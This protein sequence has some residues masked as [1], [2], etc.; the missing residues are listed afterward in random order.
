M[1]KQGS[2]Q[3]NVS[4]LPQNMTTEVNN[5]EPNPPVHLQ[6]V[7]HNCF[8]RVIL[9]NKKILCLSFSLLFVY[10]YNVCLGVCISLCVYRDNMGTPSVFVCHSHF[11]WERELHVSLKLT[12]ILVG[13]TGQEAP[14]CSLFLPPSAG[15]IGSRSNALCKCWRSE[16]RSP[17]ALL[18][19]E[20]SPQSPVPS[21]Q[22]PV[23][24]PKAQVPYMFIYI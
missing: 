12:N 11:S 5:L 22:S 3:A 4:S 13:L 19:N 15:V 17:Q 20:P 9:K 16:L 6:G 10:V 2:R 1:N 8:Y 18:H 7:K 23:P 14:V 21:P 24:S